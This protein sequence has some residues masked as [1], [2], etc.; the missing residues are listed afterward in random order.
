MPACGDGF[1]SSRPAHLTVARPAG[2][3]FTQQLDADFET[4]AWQLDRQF[5]RAEAAH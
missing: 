3:P 4:N 2:A 5:A 1:K